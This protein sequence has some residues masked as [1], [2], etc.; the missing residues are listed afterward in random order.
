MFWNERSAVVSS[1]SFLASFP[2]QASQTLRSAAIMALVLGSVEIFALGTALASFLDSFLLS[3]LAGRGGFLGSKIGSWPWN[4]ARH[5][6][7]ARI[8]IV[9]AR[10]GLGIF[11]SPSGP[12]QLPSNVPR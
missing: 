6:P 2:F 7:P 1:S 12:M 4:A 9:A 3:A 8:H 5:L 10:I 11:N